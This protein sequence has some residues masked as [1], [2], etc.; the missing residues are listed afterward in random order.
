MPPNAHLGIGK[1]LGRVG[2]KLYPKHL[3][4][5]STD[6][7]TS[8]SRLDPM[9]TALNSFLIWL[10][11]AYI[12]VFINPWTIRKKA[13]VLTLSAGLEY[14]FARMMADASVVNLQL[15]FSG[16]GGELG[17]HLNQ[18]AENADT[19]TPT[20]LSYVLNE[21]TVALL[22]HLDDYKS[23]SVSVLSTFGTNE[24]NLRFD[25][26]SIDERINNTETL[27]NVNN[28]KFHSPKTQNSAN[29]HEYN[30][31]IMVAIF[32]GVHFWLKLPAIHDK[33]DLQ[34]LLQKLRSVGTSNCIRAVEVLWTPQISSCLATAM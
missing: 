17:F 25:Q 7:Y 12:V 13:L 33:Y 3:L 2:G 6:P 24:A 19:S 10:L 27:V 16:K 9:V 32:V 21:T 26:L 11:Y 29:D 34:V 18:I 23:G 8:S 28:V 30:D 20:G 1:P 15:C 4:K 31:D 14:F 5:S 22:R